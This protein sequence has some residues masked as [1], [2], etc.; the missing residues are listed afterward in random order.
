MLPQ[1]TVP[2]MQRT[3]L[4]DLVLQV[5]LL[6]S[7]LGQPEAFLAKAPQPPPLQ[8][9]RSA[10]ESLV[11]IGALKQLPRSLS[12]S[13]SASSS[14]SSL[15]SPSSSSGAGPV[16]VSSPLHTT[17]ITT[18][19]QP[20]P[21]PPTQPQSQSLQQLPD[22]ALTALGYH[23]AHLPLDARLGK[24]LVLGAVLQCVEPVLTVCAAL[25]GKSPFLPRARGVDDEKARHA[26]LGSDHLAVVRVY[27]DWAAVASEMTNN[28]SSSSSSGG[29]GGGGGDARRAQ[30]QWCQEHCL[31][32]E[33]LSTMRDTRAQFR[34]QLAE[35]GFC[36]RLPTQQHK[37]RKNKSG[38][39]KGQGQP[40]GTDEEQ[41]EEPSAVEEF[42]DPS[43]AYG[44]EWELVRCVICAGLY[45]NVARLVRPVGKKSLA[46]VNRAGD[47]VFVHP[48]SVN[49]RT[50]ANAGASMSLGGGGGGSGA[51]GGRSN[52]LSAFLC[53]HSC[54]RTSKAFIHDSTFI[55]KY[56]LLLFGPSTDFTITTADAASAAMAANGGGSGGSGGGGGGG[57]G[58]GA[59]TK[60]S[61]ERDTVVIDG[62][63]RLRMPEEGAVLC[64]L[65][66]SEL[67]RVLRAKIQRP[68]ATTTPTTAASAGTTSTSNAA[69][70]IAATGAGAVAEGRGE[71]GF[72]GESGTD[73][74]EAPPTY[75]APVETTEDR[76]ARLAIRAVRDLVMLDRRG[77]GD[78][79]GT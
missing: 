18:T 68:G 72:E 35:I 64:K 44:R 3:P 78:E 55:G 1:Y 61:T 26:G 62:W 65:L 40:D 31:S 15:S 36:P 6:G 60:K 37:K 20:T 50:V 66:R 10:I 63:I 54:V 52:P 27:D 32:Q 4:E 45:P 56:A 39:G 59:A 67:E 53:F 75:A 70:P 22:V 9:V 49:F 16:G 28:N 24:M 19:P 5:L 48:S 71:D 13:A 79:G 76:T 23:L 30:R 34:Q 51:S 69:L 43:N 38:R 42:V 11:G 14:S 46:V 74:G 47:P 29:G 8:T 17:T 41:G 7:I 21:T 57:G 33:V 73:D 2:E 77:G 25:A 12:L 58:S